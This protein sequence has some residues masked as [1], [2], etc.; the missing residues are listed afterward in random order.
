MKLSVKIF[1]GFSLIIILS[2]LSFFINNKLSEEVNKNT[3]FLTVSESIIR[4]SALIHRNIIKMQSAFRAYLLT[5]NENFLQD[6]YEGKS[7]L[8][9]LFQA[10]RD[11]IQN[12]GKQ[13][14]KF[15]SIRMLHVGWM[16]YSESLIAAK[17][18]KNLSTDEKD[19]AT[20]NYLFQNRLQK[21]V[22]KKIT[23]EI[24]QK[25][26]EFDK[27]EYRVR[28]VR[29][30]RVHNSI[31]YTKNVTLWLAVITIT[32][33]IA[34][35]IY[36]TYLISKR[37]SSMVSLAEGISLGKFET[38][39]DTANDELTQL[40][41]SLNIM[42]QKLNKSFADLERKN[43][44]LD[45]FAYVV[46]HDLKAPLRGMYN[47]INWIEEDLEKELSDP[48]RRYLE[49]LK[50]RIHRLECLIGGLLEY[51]R[52][53]KNNSEEEQVNANELLMEI[54]DL[55]IPPGFNLIIHQPM[56][57]LRTD[58]LRLQ[59][60]FMNLVSNAVKYHG[61]TNGRIEVGCT[62]THSHY[63]FSVSDNGVGIPAEYHEKIFGMFQTLREKNESESTGIG[64][65]IVKKIVEEKKGK[66]RV[67]SEK[68][69]GASF[70]FTWPKEEVEE[71]VYQ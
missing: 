36:I 8:P 10:E 31:M 50:G 55:L 45:Q 67:F 3:E 44:E 23:D 1:I 62:E 16:E 68:G 21:E 46:S 4:N 15:D 2:I 69:K 51:A 35:G 52:A 9:S 30:E 54:K 43:R 47:V 56:P 5:D 49:M 39:E 7:E 29:R 18:K 40:S 38:I 48:L 70:V 66:I 14:V 34:S 58:K 64:L 13:M 41:S 42:S 37:I 26:T 20:Y 61:G 24:Q 59:Q 60:V 6:Y 25:F 65:A 32:I 19:H 28:L 71:T 33:G 63:K 17:Q 53:G 22:G 27:Y 12:S 57:V 11:L